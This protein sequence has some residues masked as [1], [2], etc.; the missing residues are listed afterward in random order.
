MH[1]TAAHLLLILSM[2][3][4][5][6]RGTLAQTTVFIKDDGGSF[7]CPGV[8]R[9]NN[10]N[11]GKAYCC[12]GGKL[13]LSTCEG[14]PICT[15]SSWSAK[16]VSCAATVPVTATDYGAQIKSARS[17]YLQD[18]EPTVT[19]DSVS[20]ATSGGS[21]AA[22]VSAARTAA[23]STASDSGSNVIPPG[24]AGGIV[25]GLMALWIGL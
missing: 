8:L 19:S 15:G 2:G 13:D 9:N 1:S 22:A 14:W 20:S 23:E 3:I 24:L 11:D 18:D 25:G 21:Q 17:K 12:V 6:L 16:P 4:C 7:N 5:L 10:G